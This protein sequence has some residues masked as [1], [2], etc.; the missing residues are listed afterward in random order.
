MG[1]TG[2]RDW[3]RHFVI[4]DGAAICHEQRYCLRRANRAAASKTHYAIV[5]A[6][7]EDVHSIADRSR[8]G[9]RNRAETMSQRIPA[10]EI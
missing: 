6:R 8:S 1:R 5:L 2:R 3:L 9:I 10:A 4:A 7:Y